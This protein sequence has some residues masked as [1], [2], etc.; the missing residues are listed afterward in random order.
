MVPSRIPCNVDS[1]ARE[2]KVRWWLA[3]P[4]GIIGG[5]HYSEPQDAGPRACQCRASRYLSAFAVNKKIAARRCENDSALEL[6]NTGVIL[7]WG[8]VHPGGIDFLSRS[9]TAWLTTIMELKVKGR[10]R[11]CRLFVWLLVRK[12]FLAA[13]ALFDME[14]N[15]HYL[16][17]IQLFENVHG[18]IERWGSSIVY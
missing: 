2:Q 16:Y 5:L 17:S 6:N 11:C 8:S 13:E 18:V 9:D 3:I 12:A 7:V 14:N 1:C 10:L 4:E 15:V